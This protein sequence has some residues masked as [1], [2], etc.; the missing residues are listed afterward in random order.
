MPLWGRFSDSYGNLKSI[1]ISGFLVPLVPFLWIFS[2]YFA[3]NSQSFLLPYLIIIEIFSGF[4]WAGF[5]LSAGNFIYDAVTRQRMAIC[6][7]YFN[8]LNGIGAFMGATL[9]GIISSFSFSLF[10]LGT[11]LSILPSLI[12]STSKTA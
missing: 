11:F 6:V 5:N 1:K 4:A 10:H 12:I 7:S 9:G 3:N 2:Y 8:I